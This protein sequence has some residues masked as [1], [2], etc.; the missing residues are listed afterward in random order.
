MV[1]TVTA[2]TLILGTI[3]A[4][5]YAVYTS[6]QDSQSSRLGEHVS[7]ALQPSAPFT[8]SDVMDSLHV[9]DCYHGYLI[10]SDGSFQLDKQSGFKIPCS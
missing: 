6:Y 5:N 8:A 7:N 2:I 4:F 9:A 10:N 1:K 3:M